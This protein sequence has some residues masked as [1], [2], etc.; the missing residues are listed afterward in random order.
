MFIKSTK[1]D[2]NL[3]MKF[4]YKLKS[5]DLEYCS[6]GNN[7]KVLNNINFEI[8]KNER[9]E[10]IGESGS[11]KTSLLMLLSGLEKPTRGSVIFCNNNFSKIKD[12]QIIELRKKEI[13]LIFQQFYLIPNYTALENV[14]FPMQINQISNER[15]K[16]ISL[17]S[18]LG[19]KNRINNLPSELSGGEQQRVAIARAIS[20]KPKIILADEP[21]GNLDSYNTDLVSNLLLDYSKK[22]RTSLVL[23][24]HNQRLA[25]KCERVVKLTDGS[26]D[27]KND[28]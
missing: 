3:T 4:L 24:T 14:M 5:I 17:L 9:I 8:K 7:V 15:V 6:S 11:G 2:K 20:S 27:S 10:I 19:L 21:T 18:D 12:E 26:I 13:G 1:V 25:K 28:K 16:A 22:K 23:V